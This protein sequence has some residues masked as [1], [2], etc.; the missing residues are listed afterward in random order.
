M[1]KKKSNNN[2]NLILTKLIID[3][4][5]KS[6]NTP[7]NYKQVAAKLNLSDAETRD[8]ISQILKQEAKKGILAEPERGKFILK[9]LKTYVTGKVDMTADGSAFIMTED[10]FEND[11]FIAPR[12]IRNALHGDVVKAY[13]YAKSR[14]KHKV[15]E[16]R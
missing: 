13:V 8:V 10:E 16:D 14:G 6:E 2:L 12:K 15:L 4:F 9:Q 3:V 7:L 11:I 1:S 5:E